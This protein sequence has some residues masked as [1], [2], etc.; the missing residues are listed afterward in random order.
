MIKSG[1]LKKI[2]GALDT[3]EK[4]EKSKNDLIKAT[5]K[6]YKEFSRPTIVPDTTLD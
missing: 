4:V 6:A 1:K 3:R 5:E 2:D